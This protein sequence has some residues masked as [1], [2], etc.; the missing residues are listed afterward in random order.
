MGLTLPFQTGVLTE[1]VDH[2]SHN[3][4]LYVSNMSHNSFIEFNEEGTEATPSSGIMRKLASE[5]N[6]HTS[7][8]CG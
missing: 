3:D 2:C 1:A 6:R 7:K 4:Q 8:L 5:K